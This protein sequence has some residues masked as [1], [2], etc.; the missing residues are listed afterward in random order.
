[1]VAKYSL[2]I[3]G[4][5]VVPTREFAVWSGMGNVLLLVSNRLD[6]VGGKRVEAGEPTLATSGSDHSPIASGDDPDR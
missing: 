5:M 3:G 4:F 1:M 6:R 2:W